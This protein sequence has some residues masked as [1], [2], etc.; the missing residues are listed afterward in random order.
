MLSVSP[1]FHMG[2][3]IARWQS[4]IASRQRNDLAGSL[5]NAGRSRLSEN[6]SDERTKDER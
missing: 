2:I 5:I 4:T 6:A 1:R 3:T